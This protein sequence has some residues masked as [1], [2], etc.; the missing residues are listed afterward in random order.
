LV[1]RV[2]IDAVIRPGDTDERGVVLVLVALLMVLL[3]VCAALVID[4]GNVGQ[5]RR[6]AQNA[7]DAAALAGATDI[8]HGDTTYSSVVSVIKNYV[9]S[10]YGTVSWSGCADSAPLAIQPDAGTACISWDANPPATTQVR[11]VM[12]TRQVATTFGQVIGLASFSV[13]ANAVAT[14]GHSNVNVPA[15]C[16]LCTLA[17]SNIQNGSIAVSGGPAAI[18]GDL[19]C[20]THGGITTSGTPQPPINVENNVNGCQ[21]ANMNPAPTTNARYQSDPLSF[22]P[23]NPDY[24]N[25]SAANPQDCTSGN[26]SPGVF[27]NIGGNCHLAPGLYVVTRLFGGSGGGVNLYGHGVTIFF[28]CATSGIPTACNAGGEVGGTVSIDGGAA[29]DIQACT[30]L[31]CAGTTPGGQPAP[32]TQGMVLW[33]DRN[34]TATMTIGGVGAIGFI[35]TVYGTSLNLS[36]NGTPHGVAGG[37]AAGGLCSEV[38][39]NNVSFSGQPTLNVT[40]NQSQN[41]PIQQVATIPQLLS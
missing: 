38:V 8:Q 5:E 1:H 12:P 27:R 23:N 15:P 3:C 22:L 16:A 34:N 4:V 39:V 36:V 41:V 20:N 29:A 11:V 35:G 28:A 13:S 10:N 14:V 24:S 9:A 25:L 37:C 30:A 17:G 31:P 21:P 18:D 6:Q 32:A 7:A 2:R 19:T 40:Y 26:A 33:F